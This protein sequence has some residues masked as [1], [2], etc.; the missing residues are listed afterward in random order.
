M[1]TIACVLRSGPEYRVEHVLALRD[2]VRRH[3]LMPHRFVCLSDYQGSLLD[4]G[5]QILPLKHG[6]PGWFSKIE[7]FAEFTFPGPVVYFDLDTVIVGPL[8]DIVLG[9]RFTVLKNFWRADRIGSGV[10]AWDTDLSEIYRR[11]ASDPARWM[12][13]YK[14]PDKWGDQQF[15]FDNTPIQ[16]ERWQLNYPGR[17]VSYKRDIVRLHRGRV[18]A[19]T[20]IIAFHGRPRPWETKLWPS[21]TTPPLKQAG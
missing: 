10:M 14:T 17:I 13:E 20:S 19:E 21:P 16:P 8:D 9:H 5:V 11:F 2:G 15:I 1:I 7:L 18:P 6:W 3:L 12:R 4:Q